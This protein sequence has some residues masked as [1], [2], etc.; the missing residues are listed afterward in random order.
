MDAAPFPPSSR[1]CRPARTPSVDRVPRTKP[2]A[3]SRTIVTLYRIA[4]DTPRYEAHDLTGAGAKA[5]GGR[6]N[7]PGSPVVYA[8][9]TRALACLESV[10]HLGAGALPLHRYLVEITV[11]SSLFKK[12]HIFPDTVGWDALPAGRVSI[13]W[14]TAWLRDG[15]SLLA[16]VPSV[17]VPEERN[18]LIN[19]QHPDAKRVRARKVRRWMYDGR[20]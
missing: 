10:V 20:L 16:D 9:S 3:A 6:W 12:R 8:S 4:T 11:P 14:G 15:V 5:S 13:E 2:H 17:I 18:L 7:T 19:P 1:K